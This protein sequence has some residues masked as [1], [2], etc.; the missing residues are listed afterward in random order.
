MNYRHFVAQSVNNK[1]SMIAP[2]SNREA[3][4]VPDVNSYGQK[5]E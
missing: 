3:K 5:G 1:G 2:H 4:F